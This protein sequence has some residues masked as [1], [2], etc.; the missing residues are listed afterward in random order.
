MSDA[1]SMLEQLIETLFGDGGLGSPDGEAMLSWLPICVP[2]T[3]L[4]RNDPEGRG[5]I[6]AH[7][8]VLFEQGTPWLE[9]LGVG[10]GS[11]NRGTYDP[12]RQNA[13]VAIL[14]PLGRTHTGYY[15]PR[16]WRRKSEVPTGGL[17]DGNFT[18]VA[19]EDAQWLESRDDRDGIGEWTVK[20][21]ATGAYISIKEANEAIFETALGKLGAGATEAIVHGDKLASYLGNGVSIGSLIHHLELQRAAINALSAGAVPLAVP[22]PPSDLL[23]TK[24]KVE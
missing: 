15:I 5:R 4:K 7:V 19:R 9:P 21:K 8:P 17:V 20:H 10:G 22:T 18:R 12:P 11:P 2:G 14:F 6:L 1:L 13:A 3:V 16:G 24:W 23:S